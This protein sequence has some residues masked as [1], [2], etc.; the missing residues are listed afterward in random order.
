MKATVEG[1]IGVED[2]PSSG[3]TPNSVAR[4]KRPIGK[5]QAKAKGKNTR[6]GDPKNAMGAIVQSRKEAVEE[7]KLSMDKELEADQR[8]VAAEDKRV[9]AEGGGWHWRRRRL[10]WKKINESRIMREIYFSWTHPT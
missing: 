5:K 10:P 1:V 2:E 8:R 6:D 3:E 7:R 4:T 9:V